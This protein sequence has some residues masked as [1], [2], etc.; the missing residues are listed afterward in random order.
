MEIPLF[1]LPLPTMS[2]FKDNL[3]DMRNISAIPSTLL[4][5][6]TFL[7]TNTAHAAHITNGHHKVVLT[8]KIH[9]MNTNA[10]PSNDKKSLSP[11][12][13]SI[14]NTPRRGFP[15][16]SLYSHTAMAAIH[17]TIKMKNPAVA[18]VHAIQEPKGSVHQSKLNS[19]ACR[20]SIIGLS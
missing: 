19:E 10:L 13:V 17:K 15:P 11:L 1:P 18:R 16:G 14:A 20:N 9:A 7:N 6:Y 12:V 3:P 8:K 5:D 4:A 2:I